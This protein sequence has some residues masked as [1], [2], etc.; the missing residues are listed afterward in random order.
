M[1]LEQ[2]RATPFLQ[3]LQRIFTS[4]LTFH[5]IAQLQ[6]PPSCTLAAEQRARKAIAAGPK[7]WCSMDNLHHLRNFGSKAEARALTRNADAA[8]L[9]TALW[10][11]ATQGGIPWRHLQ[12]EQEILPEN[13]EG[14]L[15]ML[16]PLLV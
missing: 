2:N 14:Q 10:E 7:G 4:H 9:R 11:K 13:D 1:A 6:R 3:N 16:R 15:Q 5:F 8:M 12:Q